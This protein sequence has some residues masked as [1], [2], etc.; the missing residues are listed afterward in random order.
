MR[1]FLKL[2]ALTLFAIL[3][4]STTSCVVLV[5]KDSGKH[6]GWFKNRK[7]PHNPYTTKHRKSENKSADKDKNYLIS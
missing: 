7:N 2:L 5:P 1:I 4:V 3:F 6:K